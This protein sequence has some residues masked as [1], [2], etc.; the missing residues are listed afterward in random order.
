MQRYFD[1]VIKESERFDFQFS[2]S[3]F[4][5]GKNPG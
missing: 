4:I 3:I 1:L 2:D 5:S